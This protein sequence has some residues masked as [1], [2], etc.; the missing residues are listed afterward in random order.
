MQ[1]GK[2][3]L[4]QRQ[5]DSKPKSTLAATLQSKRDAGKARGPQPETETTAAERRDALQLLKDIGLQIREAMRA[6]VERVRAW[7]ERET[8]KQT[9]GRRR[10]R[11]M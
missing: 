8:A 4:E 11:R 9:A 2:Q 5:V 6:A 10:G 7:R 3:R 1:A